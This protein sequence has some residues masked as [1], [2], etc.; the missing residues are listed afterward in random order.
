MAENF[1][2]ATAANATGRVLIRAAGR[3]WAPVYSSHQPDAAGRS[4]VRFQFL[5]ATRLFLPY[6][7]AKSA[8]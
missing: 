7:L 8:D 3:R 6:C 5:L 4:Q 2:L 1:F